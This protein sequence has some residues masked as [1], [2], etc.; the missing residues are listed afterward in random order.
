MK[1]ASVDIG[2]LYALRSQT[3]G[4]VTD[5]KGE[6]IETLEANKQQ[7]ITAQESVWLVPDDCKVTKAN[8]KYAL[9]A[10]GLLGG[11][12][13]LP[14]GYKRLEYLESTGTQYINTGAS[15]SNKTEIR[16]SHR[17]TVESDGATRYMRL[18]SSQADADPNIRLT[19]TQSTQP[20]G[21]K[22]ATWT[23]RFGTTSNLLNTD[24]PDFELH[25]LFLSSQKLEC[26]DAGASVSIVDSGE[27]TNPGGLLISRTFIGCIYSFALKEAGV[28]KLNLIPALD[29]TGAPCMYDT[30]SRTPFYNV[31][32][33][34]FVTPQAA[35]R[36]YSLRG[37]RVLPDWGKLTE[38]G[39]RRLYHAPANYKGDAYDYAMEHGYK[40]IVE[41]PA[42][43]E[44][45]WVPVW[46]DR[47]DCIELEWVETEPPADELSTEA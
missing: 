9:A 17:T 6:P 27:W 35:A 24:I 5:E 37:R 36:T 18:F 11:G 43:E 38:N 39:L 13:T 1:E 22:V 28:L 32:T 19:I 23:A 14:A 47:E 31:G 7:H 42:P 8:F 20:S 26:V 25:E 2:K 34:D 40:P 10:L 3:G 21:K 12:N 33:D 15:A 30:V 44:G 29:T 41:E 45:Y 4:E 16:C 46:H